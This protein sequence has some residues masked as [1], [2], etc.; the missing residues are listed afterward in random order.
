MRDIPLALP[1]ATYS[2]KDI[3]DQ[4]L[5]ELESQCLVNGIELNRFELHSLLK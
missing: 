2:A 3:G 5:A 4:V 1:V